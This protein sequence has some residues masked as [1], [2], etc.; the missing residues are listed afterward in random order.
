MVRSVIEGEEEYRGRRNTGQGGIQG[1]E[2]YRVRRNT[3]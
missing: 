3:G 2:E 1:E